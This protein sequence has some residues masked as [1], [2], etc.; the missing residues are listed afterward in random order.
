MCAAWAIGVIFSNGTKIF[1]LLRAS[2][3]STTS[4]VQVAEAS[5]PT[6]LTGFARSRWKF[7]ADANPAAVKLLVMYTYFLYSGS[8]KYNRPTL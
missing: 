4:P 1:S 8:V 3:G 5:F 2:L 6:A 7:G